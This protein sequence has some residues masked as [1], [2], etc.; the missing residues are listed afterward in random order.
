M[1]EKILNDRSGFDHSLEYVHRLYT[2]R[3]MRKP[4]NIREDKTMMVYEILRKT[5][6]KIRVI[7][8][9]PSP[10]KISRYQYLMVEKN[11][12]ELTESDDAEIEDFK[13]QEYKYKIHIKLDELIKLAS[14][15]VYL[16][17]RFNELIPINSPFEKYE[18]FIPYIKLD[19]LKLIYI[20]WHKA[21]QVNQYSKNRILMRML[22]EYK[23]KL[24]GT[25][26]EYLFH[27]LKRGET[28]RESLRKKSLYGLD[29]RYYA[30]A[31][32][33]YKK[34]FKSKLAN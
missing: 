13:K 31:E 23:E 14:D 26:L 24:T 18:G 32:F 6:K 19:P 27:S 21:L 15:K 10:E 12:F 2:E 33:I 5:K 17:P 34:S 3:D 28:K 1:N 16:N 25:D 20:I 8:R 11:R 30:I 4:G 7:L 22:W 29:K 9:P